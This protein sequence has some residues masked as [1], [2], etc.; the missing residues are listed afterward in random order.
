L[1]IARPPDNAITTTRERDRQHDLRG[2][3]LLID[4]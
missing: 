3:D 2:S 4:R 1:R